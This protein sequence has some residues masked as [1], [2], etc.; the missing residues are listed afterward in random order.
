MPTCLAPGCVNTTGRAKKAFLTF[1]R[2][3]NPA[4]IERV[5]KWF[6]NL[7]TGLKVE[8]FQFGKDS[9]ICEDH[10]DPRCFARDLKAELMN[11]P[12]KKKLIP[13]AIPTIFNHQVYNVINVDGTSSSTREFTRKRQLERESK[14]VN[15]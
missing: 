5:K 6:I 2:P 13:G 4:E 12:P 11:L 1:P 14:E 3:T 9:V 7:K 15:I 10:F 8:T